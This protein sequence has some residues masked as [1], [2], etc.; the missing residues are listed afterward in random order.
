MMIHTGY[1]NKEIMVAVQCS[2]NTVK[3][4]RH[5]LENCNGDY[6]AVARRK[7]HNRRSDCV[8]IRIPGKSAE[9]RSWKVTAHKNGASCAATRSPLVLACVNSIQ[10]L[11]FSISA[12]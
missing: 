10:H 11:A 6:E 9:K 12:C 4:I 2:L 8:R 7:Q 1:Q 5:R 3:I